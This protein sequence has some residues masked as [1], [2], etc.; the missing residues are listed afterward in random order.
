MEQQRQCPFRNGSSPVV[1]STEAPIVSFRPFTASSNRTT[2]FLL[3][4]N[5]ISLKFSVIHCVR[6]AIIYFLKGHFEGIRR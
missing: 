2:I 3:L 6:C 5:I 4:S 1:L